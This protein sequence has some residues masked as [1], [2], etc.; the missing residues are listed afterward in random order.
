M[1]DVNKYTMGDGY[2]G[3]LLMQEIEM[4]YLN[5]NYHALMWPCQSLK[6]L[7]KLRVLVKQ[8]SLSKICRN[9]RI[10]LSTGNRLKHCPARCSQYIAGYIPSLILAHLLNTVHLSGALLDHAVP[11]A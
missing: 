9:L 1:I 3:Y 6:R 2:L 10:F 5:L 4:F 11:V 8:S 7:Q